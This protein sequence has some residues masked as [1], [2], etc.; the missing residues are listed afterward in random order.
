MKLSRPLYAFYS[1]SLRRQVADGLTAEN[2]ARYLYTAGQPEPDLVI[3]TSG[4]QRMS[5]FLPWQSAYSELYFCDA[6][7]P[8]FRE[9]DFLRP[10]QL[11]RPRPALRRL[12]PVSG[13]FSHAATAPSASLASEARSGAMRLRLSPRRGTG[14]ADPGCRWS[15]GGGP[16]ASPPRRARTGSS[17]WCGCLAPG[18]RKRR[19]R[20]RRR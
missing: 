2:L 13:P 16:G 12:T 17:G 14:A 5:N 7:W 9:I 19:A 11:R 20:G 4:E 1:K 15:R 10:A 3:R 18:P 8:A 6:Y